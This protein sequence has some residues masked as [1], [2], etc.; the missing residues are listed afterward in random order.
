MKRIMIFGATGLLG[1]QTAIDLIKRGYFVIGTNKDKKPFSRLNYEGYMEGMVM[2][3]FDILRLEHVRR[4]ISEYEPDFIIH[5]AAQPIVH[6]SMSN[7]HYTMELNIR[8]TCNILEAVRCINPDIPVLIASTDKV[9]GD[10]SP[11]FREDSPLNAVYPY[12][13][14]K[15]CTD[16][17]AYSY[18]KSFGMDIYII[19]PAN[20][21]GPGD[22]H[23]SR[24]VPDT[25][26]SIIEDKAPVIRSN[27]RFIRDFIFVGDVS[28]FIGIIIDKA[29]RDGFKNA[30]IYNIGTGKP[31]PVLDIV[32]K[33]LKISG[34]DIKPVI[35]GQELKEIQAQWLDI[36]K[37]TKV[38]GFSPEFDIDKGLEI[39]YKWYL[40]A[41]ADNKALFTIP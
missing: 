7:P 39:T 14:S 30:G 17:I 36:E 40:D 27:G 4:L 28:R 18:L 23:R 9:Y 24:L 6:K 26:L 25:V 13:V 20:I 41:S 35:L 22:I 29:L 32:N 33:I 1:S 16:R 21:Y 37:A 31:F 10:G 8:S 5:L 12:D 15:L 11:P 2:P 3:C 34:R 19:R 38:F